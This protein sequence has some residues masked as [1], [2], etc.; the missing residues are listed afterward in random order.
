MVK[1]RGRILEDQISTLEDAIIY[2]ESIGEKNLDGARALVERMRKFFEQGTW[3]V[4]ER[5]LSKSQDVME[6]KWYREFLE[7][8]EEAKGGRFAGDGLC[9]KYGHEMVQIRMSN[10]RWFYE[11]RLC[12]KK[13][14]SRSIR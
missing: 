7:R 13:G 11:C 6:L 12:K 9:A 10:V 1:N 4:V 2:A 8:R 14:R 3:S 5:E